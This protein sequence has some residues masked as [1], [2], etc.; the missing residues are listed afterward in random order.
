M[1]WNPGWTRRSA[2]REGGAVLVEYALALTLLVVGSIGA[3]QFLE[4]E[5]EDEVDRQ[6]ECISQRPPPESSCQPEALT[7]VT[8]PPPPPEGGYP[9]GSAENPIQAQIT[10]GVPTA[11]TSGSV[12]EVEAEVTLTADEGP[13][14]G[15]LVGTR[16][17]VTQSSTGNRIGDFFFVE[18]S[19]DD[20][21]VCQIEFDSRWPEVTQIEFEVLYVGAEKFYEFEDVTPVVVDRPPD[22]P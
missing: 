18:C 11:T 13:I 16:V 17:T 20:D 3:I 6:A 9:S 5:T 10:L 19:T 21:G 1:A 2:R 8:P 22:T 12:F 7:P 15:E 4:D 14:T